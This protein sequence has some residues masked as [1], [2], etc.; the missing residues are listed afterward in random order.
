MNRL[1]VIRRDNKKTQTEIA[2]LLNVNAKTISRWESGETDIKT[3]QAQM[4]ADYFGV[5]IEYLLGNSDIP[6]PYPHETYTPREGVAWEEYH[7]LGLQKTKLSFDD[8]LSL[9]KMKLAPEYFDLIINFSNSSEENQ[10]KILLLVQNTAF[11]NN[12]ENSKKE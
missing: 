1:K 6:N 5:S 3:P 11:L 9:R 12:V 8:Y 10:E 7:Q 2:N 4:L